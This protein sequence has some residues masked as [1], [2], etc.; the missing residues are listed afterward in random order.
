MNICLIALY[1]CSSPTSTHDVRS[2]PYAIYAL[3]GII[4]SHLLNLGRPG[5]ERVSALAVLDGDGSTDGLL[6]GLLDH[7]NTLLGVLD[8]LLGS[9]VFLNQILGGKVNICSY[10]KSH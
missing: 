1:S 10:E 9:Q 7:L 6:G 5:L 8:D 3:R 4:C 2:M